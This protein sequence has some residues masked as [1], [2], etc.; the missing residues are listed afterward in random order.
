MKFRYVSGK[1]MEIVGMMVVGAALLAG[2]GLTPSG[3]PS[4]GGE[5]ALLGVGGMLFT[6]G[7]LLER[8]A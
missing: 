7:W 4:M 1:V 3:E 2:L 8:G 6:M 5:M